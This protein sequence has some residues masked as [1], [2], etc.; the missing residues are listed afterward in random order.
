MARRGSFSLVAMLVINPVV[1]LFYQNCSVVPTNAATP[2]EIV[3]EV[4]SIKELKTQP[5]LACNQGKFACPRSSA[6]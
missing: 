4:S 1:I 5:T 3:R 6:D 2:K